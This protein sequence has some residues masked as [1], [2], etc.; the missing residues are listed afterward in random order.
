MKKKKWA[1]IKEILF[2]Y[3]AISKALYWINT[4]AAMN[5]SDMGGAG[6]AVLMRFLMQDMPIILIVLAFFALD[7]L[8]TLKQSK[9][10]KI[11]ENI[12]Y[13]VIGFGVVLGVMLGYNWLV[14][15]FFLMQPIVID[16]W[17]A[18]LGVGVLWYLAIIVI[19]NLKFYFKAKT[20]PEYT[21]SAEDKVAMLQVLLDEGVLTQEEFARKRETVLGG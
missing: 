19:L 5:Q 13:Y 15:Q 1:P 4:V 2:S 17:G 14:G 3:L 9:H 12:V 11:L 16:S 10:S 21:R 20:K 8:V 7:K 18:F 6:E